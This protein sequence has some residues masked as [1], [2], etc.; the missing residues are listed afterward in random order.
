M[1]GLEEGPP[2]V[3]LVLAQRVVLV[4]VTPAAVERQPQ[5]GLGGVLDHVVEPVVAVEEVEVSGQEPGGPQPLDVGRGE[6]VGGEHVEHHAVVAEVIV[7]RFDDP[8]APAPNALLA[9]P[10][11]LA[12]PEPVGVSPDV[13]PVPAPAFAVVKALEQSIDGSSVGIGSR[14]GEVFVELLAGGRQA[15]Q[16]E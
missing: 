3:V 9:V 15:D 1:V 14:I 13:H 16:V 8:L 4:V 10:H 11:L 6:L 5:E 12:E 7:E 2:R